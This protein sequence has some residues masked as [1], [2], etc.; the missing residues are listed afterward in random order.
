M[1]ERAYMAALGELE[2]LEAQARAEAEPPQALC[3]YMDTLRRE[4]AAYEQGAR[5]KGRPPTD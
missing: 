2:R 4:I 1:D 5:S 3:E